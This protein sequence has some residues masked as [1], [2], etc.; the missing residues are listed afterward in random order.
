MLYS[1]SPYLELCSLVAHVLKFNSD[2]SCTSSNRL[3][4]TERQ[5]RGAH[6]QR[7][8][9]VFISSYLRPL[10]LYCRAWDLFKV[11]RSAQVSQLIRSRK[12]TRNSIIL[13]CIINVLYTKIVV[14]KHMVR[15]TS[16]CTYLCWISISKLIFLF[17]VSILVCHIQNLEILEQYFVWQSPSAAQRTSQ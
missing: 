5:S 17:E 11:T 9:S 14:Q 13:D 2:L 8:F 7:E 3:V 6:I 15:L 12:T 1:N 4:G 16:L 10:G